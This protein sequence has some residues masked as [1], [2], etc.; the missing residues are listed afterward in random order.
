MSLHHGGRTVRRGGA[1]IDDD[2]VGSVRRAQLSLMLAATRS[3]TLSGFGGDRCRNSG[4]RTIPMTAAGSMNRI[5]VVAGPL[6]STTTLHGSI[7]PMPGS[8]SQGAMG[9]LWIARAEYPV[10]PEV[11]TELVLE[12]RSDV[13]LGQHSEALLLQQPPDQLLGLLWRQRRF[14]FEPVRCFRHGTLWF[15]HLWL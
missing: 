8:A 4:L 7:N 12:G 11:D 5:N 3:T 6:S 13:D 1:N 10:G 14:D 9:E 15:A 2:R